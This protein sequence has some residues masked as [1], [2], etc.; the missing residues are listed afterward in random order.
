MERIGIF[1]K[2]SKYS[3]K[4]RHENYDF[5]ESSFQMFLHCT[6]STFSGSPLLQLKR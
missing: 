1:E 4:W 3:K 2:P 5:Q 6:L